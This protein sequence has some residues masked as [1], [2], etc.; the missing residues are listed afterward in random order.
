[1]WWWIPIK[2]CIPCW[3][4]NN[5]HWNACWHHWCNNWCNNWN[6]CHSCC[7]QDGKFNKITNALQIITILLLLCQIIINVDILEKTTFTIKI[8]IIFINLSIMFMI[9]N[10]IIEADTNLDEMIVIM[11]SFLEIQIMD[12]IDEILVDMGNVIN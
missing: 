10:H 6:W 7:C 2:L 3:W 8:I 1:M 4:N 9:I 11:I 5:W 12:L